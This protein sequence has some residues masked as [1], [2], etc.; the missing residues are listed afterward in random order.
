M[1]LIWVQKFN[2]VKD[3]KMA[4]KIKLQEVFLSLL[5]LSSI[6]VMW[7]LTLLVWLASPRISEINYQG[8]LALDILR[9]VF[10]FI[11]IFLLTL[12][13]SIYARKKIP[14]VHYFLDVV[15]RFSYPV[16]LVLGKILQFPPHLIKTSYISVNNNIIETEQKKFSSE[17][18]LLL[19]SCRYQTPDCTSRLQEID[20]DCKNCQRCLLG[21]IVHFCQNKK[22]EMEIFENR[23]NLTQ[24]IDHYKLIL[25]LANVDETAN[26]M[27]LSEDWNNVYAINED[28]FQ[29]SQKLLDILENTYQKLV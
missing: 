21:E 19:V 20:E 29:P 24:N 15:I 13:V 28:F 2:R 7:L 17:N 3:L 23:A 8:N 26:L 1:L 5:T 22:I 6:I 25:V 10:L 14:L 18:I 12:F 16:I 11:S 9:I 4:S 27:R